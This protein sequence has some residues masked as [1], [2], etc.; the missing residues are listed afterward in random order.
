MTKGV[1][2]EKMLSLF[3]T[4]PESDLID[5]FVAMGGN[6]GEFQF[7]HPSSVVRFTGP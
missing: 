7:F 3:L 6:A 1:K 4:S 5:A 2:L